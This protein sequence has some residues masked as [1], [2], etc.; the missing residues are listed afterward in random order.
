MAEG[1]KASYDDLIKAL[2]AERAEKVKLQVALKTEESS[3]LKM[4]M[5]LNKLSSSLSEEKRMQIKLSGELQAALYHQQRAV[6]EHDRL[7][8]VLQEVRAVCAELQA[9]VETEMAETKKLSNQLQDSNCR[10]NEKTAELE[11]NKGIQVELRASLQKEHERHEKLSLEHQALLSELQ[12]VTSATK[13]E[14]NQ[15]SHEKKNQLQTSTAQVHHTEKQSCKVKS[16]SLGPTDQ[17]P[18]CEHQNHLAELQS[19]ASKHGALVL[20]HRVVLSDYQT[21]Q[22]DHRALQSAQRELRSNLNKK[23][24][25]ILRMSAALTERESGRYALEAEF[26][27]IKGQ[28]QKSSSEVE[29]LTVQLSSL[30]EKDREVSSTMGQLRGTV[31]ALTKGLDQKRVDNFELRKEVLQARGQL[32]MTTAELNKELDQQN[33]DNVSLRQELQQEKDKAAQQ[34]R[35]LEKHGRVIVEQ[36]KAMK[37]STELDQGVTDQYLLL[38]KELKSDN[39]RLQQQL[40][41]ETDRRRA[42]GDKTKDILVKN[43]EQLEATRAKYKAALKDAS[44]S[45]REVEEL[46]AKLATREMEEKEFFSETTSANSMNTLVAL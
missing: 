15:S 31:A 11:E 39:A 23:Q 46:E 7:A 43:K 9:A 42:H 38:I 4:R 25:C 34:R 1:G 2:E 6:E 24:G 30:Q 27:T 26:H 17:S 5:R 20:E 41:K 10:L 40:L 8:A 13:A 16:T 35:N 44:V 12:E 3:I 32:T 29:G 14:T 33:L 37:Q 36:R 19:L 45:H 28:L 18:P 22:A 21:L